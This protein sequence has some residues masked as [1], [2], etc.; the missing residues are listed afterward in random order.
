M[1]LSFLPLPDQTKTWNVRGWS[2]RL[3]RTARRSKGCGDKRQDGEEEQG[4][5]SD[6]L[7]EESTDLAPLDE[8]LAE[9][10]KEHE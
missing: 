1:L 9:G 3:V 7:L 10:Y 6:Y 8:Y 5:K 4:V 2:E